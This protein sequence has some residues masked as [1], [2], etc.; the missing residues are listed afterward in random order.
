MH[1]LWIMSLVLVSAIGSSIAQGKTKENCWQEAGR[2]Y[3]IDPWLL[4]AIAEQESNLNPLAIN[5]NNDRSEDVGIMQIN[6]FWFEKIKQ[7]GIKK[8]N[9]FDSCT[10]IRVGAW[11]LH[12]SIQVFGNNW[13]AV[14]AY[15]AGTGSSKQREALR[16]QYAQRVRRRYDRLMAQ[17]L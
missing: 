17:Q 3:H 14:G 15:N 16:Q 4:Y 5:T 8:Q 13:R 11:I 2:T 9:L 1:S 6:S 7:F 12:Q 10:N